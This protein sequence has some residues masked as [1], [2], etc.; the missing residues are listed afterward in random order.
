MHVGS[1]RRGLAA[2]L[3][4]G[5]VTPRETVRAAT[6]SIVRRPLRYGLAT[7]GVA[8]GT[9]MLVSLLAISAGL[10]HA[11]VDRLGERPL[12]TTVQV[13][14]AAPRAG[15]AP[16]Q[17]DARTVDELSRLPRVREALPVIV[18]PASLR[19]GDRAPSGTAM[20]VSPSGRA[21]YALS[22]GRAP[23][24]DE[25]DAV[26]LTA[27]GTRA[28]GV[29]TDALLGR[30]AVLE[31][32]RGEARR[33]IEARIVGVLSDEIPGLAIV[34]LALAED[35]L[36]WIAT[37]ETEAA[38]DLRLAQQAAAAL[39]FGGRAVASDLTA[40][41]YTSIWVIADSPGGVSALR[42]DIERLG[43]AAV[44]N[45]AATAAV[46][47]LFRLVNAALAAIAG[48]ALVVAA[49]GVVNALVTS[50][51]ERTTEIGILKALGA[52]DPV[53]ERLFL[54][55]AAVIGVVGGAAGVGAGAVGSL[56]ALVAAQG[57]VGATVVPRIDATLVLSGLAVA[58]GVSL[59]AGWLPARRASRVVPAEALRAE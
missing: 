44:S 4:C 12:L 58:L 22:R 52:S 35:A 16:R 25:R 2:D 20:G 38:R 56:A 29:D 10:Q 45:E 9:A 53:V 51:S 55:E 7:L 19:V 3:R 36:A 14:P 34:P 39:L 31:L 42:R 27:A 26:V 6:R 18:I 47:E 33:T 15:E 24:A 21:P 50:V 49:L 30:P 46:E 28:L 8:L 11:L 48:I 5:D 1:K 57:A 59:V 13:T 40:S 41:R 43:Y 17:L 37:G 54:T 32:R 23:A